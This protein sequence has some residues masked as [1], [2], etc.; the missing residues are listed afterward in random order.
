MV[1]ALDC[2]I[3]FLDHI[4]I[5]VSGISDG[6]E[7]RTIDNLMTMLRKLV[8]EVKCTMFVVSHLKKT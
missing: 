1:Q 5:V 8:E 2:K 4:S 7:R 3:I 6:D